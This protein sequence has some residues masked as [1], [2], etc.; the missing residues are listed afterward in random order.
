[1]KDLFSLLCG[2]LGRK[3]TLEGRCDRK[4]RYVKAGKLKV[5]YIEGKRV[6][7]QAEVEALKLDK[8][9]LVHRAFPFLN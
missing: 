3:L 4:R 6:Y 1:M 2:I 5:K 8:E 9:V 7:E